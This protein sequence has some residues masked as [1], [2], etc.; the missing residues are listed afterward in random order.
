MCSTSSSSER[1]TRALNVPCLVG[2]SDSGHG[3]HPAFGT[4]PVRD[5]VGNG[6]D[7]QRVVMRKAQQGRPP[8]H[9]A[10][11]VEERAEHG[12]GSDAGKPCQVRGS[13]GMSGPCEHAALARAQ[14]KHVAR[15]SELVGPD[16]RI[17]ERTNGRRAIGGR[18]AAGGAAPVVDRDGE[19]AAPRVLAVVVAGDHRR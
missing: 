17:C 8:R 5:Q 12:V 14:G 16:A 7:L 10:V 4:L 11:V 13:L 15:T 1:Y 18:D 3:H 6:H 19:C 9:A 2:S